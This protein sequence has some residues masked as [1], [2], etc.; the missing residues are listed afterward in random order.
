M[1][2]ASR[3]F[4]GEAHDDDELDHDGDAMDDDDDDDSNDGDE[5]DEEGGVMSRA[6]MHVDAP[7][8]P[9]PPEPKLQPLEMS[10]LSPFPVTLPAPKDGKDPSRLIPLSMLVGD[11]AVLEMD[12]SISGDALLC[13]ARVWCGV[14]T[15]DISALL[16][17]TASMASC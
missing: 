5:D 10:E 7:E 4:F 3:G 6:A 8:L 17:F 13:W 12:M 9:P 16:T 1:K 15:G 2:R 11:S 14:S